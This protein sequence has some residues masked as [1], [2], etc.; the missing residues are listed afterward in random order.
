[1]PVR[2]RALSQSN[3][4]GHF[5]WLLRQDLYE[6]AQRCTVVR[7][8]DHGTLGDRVS[9]DYTLLIRENQN[10]FYIPIR[11][12]FCL[13]RTLLSFFLS[14]ALSAACSQACA[15]TL[16]ICSWRKFCP[17]HPGLR[18]RG[19]RE[20]HCPCPPR[21]FSGPYSAIWV[22]RVRTFSPGLDPQVESF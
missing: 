16:L 10:H 20:G 9:V 17:G 14:T 6:P 2:T 18:T 3:T 5:Q 19:A 11:I 22:P 7:D 21:P 13:N 15:R 1:V 8:V 12:D 4:G